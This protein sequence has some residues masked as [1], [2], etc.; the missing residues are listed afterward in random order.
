M[1][2][3]A[4]CELEGLGERMTIWH[5]MRRVAP[6]GEGV[7]KVNFSQVYSMPLELASRF[8][9]RRPANDQAMIA[10]FLRGDVENLLHK[11]RLP[12]GSNRQQIVHLLCNVVGRD[13]SSTMLLYVADQR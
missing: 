10:L 8:S 7:G 12:F 13:P 9:S 2:S 3:F 11:D 1:P 6:R 4:L 5:T